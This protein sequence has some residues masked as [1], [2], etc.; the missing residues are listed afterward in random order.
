MLNIGAEDS[1]MHMSPH[2][3]VAISL[4]VSLP[5]QM[6]KAFIKIVKTIRMWNNSCK[7]F[8]TFKKYIISQLYEHVGIFSKRNY[9]WFIEA[10][11][12]IYTTIILPCL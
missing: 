10:S 11:G 8:T 9:V 5:Q 12:Y 4:L 3:W 1:S 7:H 2:S 6:K